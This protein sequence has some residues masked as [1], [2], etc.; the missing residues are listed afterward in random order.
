M[1]RKDAVVRLVLLVDDYDRA[2]DFYCKQTGLFSIDVNF[3]FGP[4][5]RNVVLSYNNPRSPLFLVPHLA[6][7]PK[8]RASIG[9]QAGDFPFVALPVEDCLRSYDLLQNA[10]V[11][12]VGELA[13]LPY[14]CQ[15]ILLDPFGNQVCLFQE[16]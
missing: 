8:M 10:G 5:D 2:I 3:E 15:A 1:G 13:E 14:G 11:Q 4:K 9:K 7:T 12:F 16:Y 6:V